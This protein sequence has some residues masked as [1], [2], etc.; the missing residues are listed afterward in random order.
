MQSIVLLLA[1]TL[2]VLYQQRNNSPG[3]SVQTKSGKIRGH[4]LT[5]YKGNKYEAYQ[6][7]P[8]ALPP[9]GKR[10]FEVRIIKYK[11]FVSQQFGKNYT[12]C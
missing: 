10:R 7:I 4:Y 1:I 9:V 6:G 12:I 11:F 2:L 3:P 5:S 8:Y